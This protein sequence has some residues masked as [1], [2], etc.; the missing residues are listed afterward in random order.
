MDLLRRRATVLGWWYSRIASMACWISGSPASTMPMKVRLSTT[1][2]LSLDQ[3]I[4][5]RF[6][7]QSRYSGSVIILRQLSIRNDRPVDTMTARVAT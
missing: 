2:P 4:I 1:L 5:G 7:R 6:A 3:D